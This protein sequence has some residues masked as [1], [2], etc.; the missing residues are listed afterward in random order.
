MASCPPDESN[1][2]I[3]FGAFNKHAAKHVKQAAGAVSAGSGNG[4]LDCAGNMDVA[5]E[6]E[7]SAFFLEKSRILGYVRQ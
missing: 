4:G 6:L 2:S 5:F 1:T 3:V 7:S